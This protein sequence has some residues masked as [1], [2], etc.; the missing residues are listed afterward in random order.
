MSKKKP[1]T[2]YRYVIHM[3][4]LK[5]ARCKYL[6]T[7]YEHHVMGF[8]LVDSRSAACVCISFDQAMEFYHTVKLED[9]LNLEHLYISKFEVV[10]D[11]IPEM[12]H[13]DSV[14]VKG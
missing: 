3:Y 4:D 5:D 10:E 13:C 8:K 2:E 7:S 12:K 14:K 9:Y 11:W 6:T 1:K